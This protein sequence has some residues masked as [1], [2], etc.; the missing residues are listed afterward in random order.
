MKIVKA[1]FKNFRLLVDTEIDFSGDDAKNLTVIRA[2]NGSGK[3]TAMS[4]LLWG[5]YG[6]DVIKEKIYPMT[7]FDEGMKSFDI[8]VE[9]D[10]ITE[11]V[12]IKMNKTIVD[13]R[14]YKIIRR[15]TEVVSDDGA[16]VKRKQDI[17]KMFEHT[18]SGDV[19]VLESR[20]EQI[21]EKAL[22]I[23]LKDVYF[24]DG[25]KALTF[26]EST[27]STREK[28]LRVKNAV[29]SLLSINDLKTVTK[30]LKDVKNDFARS[31]DSS[32]YGKKFAETNAEISDLEDWIADSNNDVKDKMLEKGNVVES[33]KG[34]EKRIEEQLKLGDKSALVSDIANLKQL[35]ATSEKSKAN[36]ILELCKLI[37]SK[38]VSSSMLINKLEDVFVML[39]DMKARDN[40]PKQFI[41]VL[42]D[43]LAR[44]RCVCGDSLEPALELNQAKIKYIKDEIASSEGLDVINARA[45]NLYFSKEMLFT[46]DDTWL[47]S[48]NSFAEGF[49]EA[50]KNIRDINTKLQKKL[51]LVD[52]IDDSLLMQLR[53]QEKNERRHL[54][55]LDV[56]IELELEE[57]ARSGERLARLKK[58]SEGFSSKLS[59]KNDSGGRLN[60]ANL[61]LKL[62]ERVLDRVSTS[63]VA[64][65][66][67]EMNSIFLDMIGS[68]KE[69]NHD[70]LIRSASLTEEYDILVQGP[71]GQAL[72]PDTELNGASRR[73][74]S[75]AFILAL[76]KVS[77]VKAPNIID[78]PLG[79][80]S[81]LVKSS[82]VE[83]LVKNGS[84]L[85]MFLTYDEIRSVETILDRYAGSSYTLSFSGH[86]PKMLKNKP[87]FEGRSF[88]C[89]CNHRQCCSVC[90]R[91]D[92]TG[93]E[94]RN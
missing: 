53:L 78:T 49:F 19:P 77:K 39:E 2:D 89:R 92:Q 68:D 41:P 72:N 26:I 9:I 75:L 33:I 70:G 18:D 13:E 48:Y 55:E 52:G 22:P 94:Y 47:K 57:I 74:I 62:F 36:F 93:M 8:Q 80:T 64:N 20:V 44:N 16:S 31:I 88:L 40:F 87:K 28:R 79:M 1:K 34:L 30:N 54:S 50:D 82:I 90:E 3:T 24:T 46:S 73:A 61:A 81:G 51:E 69:A 59:K 66:S 15:T 91:L 43:I 63:E 11:D 5:F 45:S 17:V 76:T 7:L 29:E 86:F 25:D 84:Q 56:N 6:S 4:A 21:I 58:D 35:K 60:L 67:R 23:Q 14:K 32:D 42:K 83:N 38:S 10:F 27:A 65:V 12:S 85:I 37:S 71:R